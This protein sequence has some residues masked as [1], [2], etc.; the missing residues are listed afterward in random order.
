MVNPGGTGRAA[1]VISARPAPLPPRVSFILPLPS[2]L[3]PPKEYTY[4]TALTVGVAIASLSGVEEILVLNDCC[5][6]A[7]K[8]QG[9]YGSLRKCLSNSIHEKSPLG[10]GLEV[11]IK[12]KNRYKSIANSILVLRKY[13]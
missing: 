3:P 9:R 8:L 13:C 6:R 11:N 1:L 7:G 5:R 12:I 4:L 2:A 10:K